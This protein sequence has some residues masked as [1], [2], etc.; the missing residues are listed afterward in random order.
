M[1]VVGQGAGLAVKG[2]RPFAGLA[3]PVTCLAS[4]LV[5]LEEGSG[6]AVRIP[7][8]PTHHS[9]GIQNQTLFTLQTLGGIWTLTVCTSLVTFYRANMGHINDT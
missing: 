6:W 9:V 4:K 5:V 1:E 8:N 7:S 2:F 3:E